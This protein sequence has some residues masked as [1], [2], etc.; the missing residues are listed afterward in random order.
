MGHPLRACVKLCLRPA[1]TSHVTWQLAKCS[2]Q[3]MHTQ[4]ANTTYAL[5]Y[6]FMATYWIIPHCC[7]GDRRS[8]MFRMFSRSKEAVLAPFLISLKEKNEVDTSLARMC[9]SPGDC[10]VC[11]TWPSPHGWTLNGM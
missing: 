5:G 10:S 9:T 7:C 6:R 11:K 3:P 1:T 8:R 4:L 2:Q